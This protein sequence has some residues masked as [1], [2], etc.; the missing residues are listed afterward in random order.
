MSRLATPDTSDPVLLVKDAYEDS[1]LS[2][3]EDDFT[4]FVLS[5]LRRSE[6]CPQVTEIDSPIEDLTRLPPHE[7]LS[8]RA[9]QDPEPPDIVIPPEETDSLVEDSTRLSPSKQISLTQA[10]QDLEPP[11]AVIPPELLEPVSRY[12]LRRRA[13]HQIRPYAVEQAK[14]KVALASIPEAM[15]KGKHLDLTEHDRDDHYVDEPSPPRRRRDDDGRESGLLKDDLS[16]SSSEIDETRREM[17]R[18]WRESRMKDREERSRQ[19]TERERKKRPKPFPMSEEQPHAGPSR[20]G[21]VQLMYIRLNLY[22]IYPI[23]HN[24]LSPRMPLPH[25]LRTLMILLRVGPLL[26]AAM[27]TALWTSPGSPPR[28]LHFIP[29]IW[30]RL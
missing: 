24:P 30:T 14:Y 11:E 25:I 12:S 5:P 1:P 7:Q 16:S 15:V 19:I 27:T 4:P 26:S 3:L 29:K 9:T 10:T 28:T 8:T 23:D 18:L 2:E 20:V 6:T 22:S 21:G 13:I 17:K